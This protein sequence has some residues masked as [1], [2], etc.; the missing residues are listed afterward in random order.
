MVLV[1]S[2]S[3]PCPLASGVPQ[4]TMFSHLLLNILQVRS[5]GELG[6]VSSMLTQLYLALPIRS[7]VDNGNPELESGEE[8]GVDEGEK[9]MKLSPDKNGG[10]VHGI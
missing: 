7:Q 1:D 5:S 9:N 2:C 10:F 6:C 8:K 4:R 3:S